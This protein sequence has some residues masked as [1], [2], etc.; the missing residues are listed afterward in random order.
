MAGRFS[1]KWRMRITSPTSHN[2]PRLKITKGLCFHTRKHYTHTHTFRFKN[3]DQNLG[4]NKSQAKSQGEILFFLRKTGFLK[5]LCSLPSLIMTGRE[6]GIRAETWFKIKSSSCE[7]LR[8]LNMVD[9]LVVAPGFFLFPFFY[10]DFL[11]LPSLILPFIYLASAYHFGFPISPSITSVSSTHLLG[12]WC[13][14]SKEFAP[15]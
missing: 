1:I 4:V 3:K 13:G 7:S 9:L 8:N 12:V 11:S 2:H 15:V 6:V 5:F 14:W 10:Y